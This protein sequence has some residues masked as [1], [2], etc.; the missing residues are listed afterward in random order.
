MLNDT[1]RR[2]ETCPRCHRARSEWRSNNDEGV[3]LDGQTYCCEG[4]AQN[5]RC[6]CTLNQSA[7]RLE[8]NV[9]DGPDAKA[10]GLE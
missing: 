6:T 2:N 8:K 3:T 5:T 10:K 1:Q 9:L 7:V 4:C